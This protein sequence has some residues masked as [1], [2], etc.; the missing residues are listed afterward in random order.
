MDADSLDIWSMAIQSVPDA[1][2]K[3]SMNAIL[4]TLPHRQN[5]LK[6]GKVQSSACPLC[7][8]K[9]TLVHILNHCNMALQQRHYYQRH[10]TI[11][12]HIVDF[13]RAHI[14]CGYLIISVDLPTEASIRPPFLLSD[15]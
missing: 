4:D 1:V 3:F 12:K 2:M 15:F 7:S 6:W 10:G 11:L 5:L 8:A 9:Q 14:P 13:I